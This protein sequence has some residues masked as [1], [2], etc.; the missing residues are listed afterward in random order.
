MGKSDFWVTRYGT[1]MGKKKKLTIRT[2]TGIGKS[3]M[4]FRSKG[5]DTSHSGYDPH[6]HCGV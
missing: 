6:P 4:G 2:G 3:K 5:T 1:N